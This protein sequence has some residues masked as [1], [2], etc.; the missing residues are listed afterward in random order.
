MRD[1]RGEPVSGATPAALERFEQGLVLQ[2]EGR[3]DPASLARE[4]TIEAPGFA[5]AHALEACA[6]LNLRDP[7]GGVRAMRAL[8][9]FPGRPTLARERLHFHG[10]AALAHGDCEGA[11]HAYDR[12]LA[13]HPRD[14]LAL[15]AAHSCDYHL[16]DAAALRDRPA[17]VRPAWSEA[18][19]GF[20]AVLSM[21]AF[22]LGEC[23]DYARAEEA[24]QQ[25]L[26]LDPFDLR[27]H[28]AITHVLEMLDRS[29]AGVRWM[30]S[31][32]KYWHDGGAVAG[33]LWW[34]LAL[35]W[36]DEGEHAR[37]LEILERRIGAGT[38]APVS[39]LVDASSLLW[40]LGLAGVEAGARWQPLADCWESLPVEGACAFNDLHAMMAYVGAGRRESA[41]RLLA[42]QRDAVARGGLIG[43]VVRV[44]GLPACRALEAFG[45]GAFAEAAAILG[46][47]APVAH[48]MG[49]SRAQRSVLQ[50]TRAAALRRGATV[51]AA[52]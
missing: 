28:H 39:R 9:R 46:H 30:A 49:G 18:D 11:R 7:A 19:R 36:L 42:A 50:L 47:L 52:A 1:L 34:H 31:R 8:A 5:M 44:A 29:S 21:H 23:G 40:R 4:A 16:G 24:G 27:A 17:W 43:A 45:R 35:H 37:V 2:L 22:G 15:Q 51:L 20:H 33:H 13:E 3:G 38:G 25:A 26:E 12:L 10:I 41:A 32:E 48:R 14:V 6:C